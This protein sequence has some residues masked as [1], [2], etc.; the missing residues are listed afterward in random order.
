M[1]IY[2]EKALVLL[3]MKQ[4][5]AEEYGK[6]VSGIVELAQKAIRPA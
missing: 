1:T 2:D 3:K 5:H 4:A 6:E